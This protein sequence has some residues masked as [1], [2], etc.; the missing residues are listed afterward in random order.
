MSKTGNVSAEKSD[1]A[2]SAY[3]P[4]GIYRRDNTWIYAIGDYSVLYLCTK[5]YLR[6]IFECR[7]KP[8][9]YRFVENGS[10]TSRGMLL[11]AGFVELTAAKVLRFN[12]DGDE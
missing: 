7:R 4:S 6:R 2:N 10:E 11:P 12:G 3:V 1:P 8:E 9:G 5:N